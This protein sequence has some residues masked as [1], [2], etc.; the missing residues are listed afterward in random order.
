M[1]P[2]NDPLMIVIGNEKYRESS[3]KWM[4]SRGISRNDAEDLYQ[5]FSIR[6]MSGCGNYDHSISSKPK[7]YLNK[8][9]NNMIIDE[10]RRKRRRRYSNECELSEDG[11]YLDLIESSCEEPTEAIDRE[12]RREIID[13]V[14]KRIPGRHVRAIREY[15][16]GGR[17]YIDIAG[18]EKILE[19]NVKSRIHRARVMFKEIIRKDK[20]ECQLNA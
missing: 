4:L 16:W 10:L 12:R 15:Y 18:I 20:L 2:E 11:N 19:G 17:S 8:V 9:L 5:D 3:I 14:F 7:Y 6:V 13:D 1:R